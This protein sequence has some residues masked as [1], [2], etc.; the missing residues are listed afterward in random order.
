[1]KRYLNLI[2]LL[3]FFI[4]SK[5]FPQSVGGF[6]SGSTIFCDS[7]NSGFIALNG[8]NGSILYWESSINNGITWTALSNITSTQSYYN[9]NKTTLFRAIVKD[10]SFPQD[11]SSISVITV[12]LPGIAGT[13]S[14]GG[15][16][17]NSSGNGILTLTGTTG[18]VLFWQSSVN[19]GLTW[20]NISNTTATLSY[21][22]IIQ[23]TLFRAVVQSNSVCPRDTSSIASINI[24]PFSVSG[25][26]SAS[27]SVCSGLNYD[28][29]HLTG[30]IGNVTGW[31]Y[32]VNNGLTWTSAANNSQIQIYSNITKTTI[33]K[34]I[35][36]SGVCLADTT[37][38]VTIYVYPHQAVSAG[39]DKTIT[40]FETVVLNGTG[41][42]TPVWS[43]SDGLSAINVFEP[44]ASPL[45]TTTY[46]LTVK[47]NHQCIN[48]DTVVVNVVVPIPTAITPN[49]DGVNDFFLIDKIE[50]YQQNSITVFN[51]WGS[52]VFKE[53]PY[54]NDWDGKSSNGKDLPDDT[55]FF[56][57][58]YGNGDKPVSGY[59]LIK[60]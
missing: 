2:V 50:D 13:I 17:C 5:I 45:N 15:T 38:P 22:P 40:R 30:N 10:G 18:S 31:L 52:V 37:S 14:G 6:T 56:I 23:N 34:V 8:H 4:F 3:S 49:N 59:V 1:M 32:S 39:S 33:Y 41:S 7:V 48:S 11:T 28:T 44:S 29:L 36:K 9:L 55:Y 20:N 46:V 47:D 35:V 12:H 24:N 51:R 25:V 16:F 21:T 43:P 19:A 53:S 26:I 42:G 58:D 60:R 27:D 54:K 57:F